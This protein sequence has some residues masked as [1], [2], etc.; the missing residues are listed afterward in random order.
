MIS[1]PLVS[2]CEDVPSQADARG[3]VGQVRH[4]EIAAWLAS[5]VE[6]IKLLAERIGKSGGV[7]HD[8]LPGILEIPADT[9]H[10]IG[11]HPVAVARQF[12]DHC[13]TA[14]QRQIAAERQCPDRADRPQA[15]DVAGDR[16]VAVDGAC[17]IVDRRGVEGR[18]LQREQ[19]VIHDRV[20][21]ISRR[22]DH[23]GG[24]LIHESPR[25]G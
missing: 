19:A 15:V 16:P 17:R 2:S 9:D 3:Q 1:K 13:R 24:S 14:Q 21:K 18:V 7:G 8:Q 25:F 22:I 5:K 23:T 12:D 4:A 20:H 6:E 11:S 10:I